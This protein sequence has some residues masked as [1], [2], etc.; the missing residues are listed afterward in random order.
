MRTLVITDLHL[1]SRVLGLLGAQQECVKRI[2]REEKPDDVIIMGDVFMHRKPSPSSLLAFKKILNYITSKGAT[3]TVLRGNHDSETKADDGVTALSVFDYAGVDIVTLARCDHRKKRAYIPHYEDEE[4][5]IEF[6]ED[7]PSH[8][9]AFGHFGYDGCLN[10]VGDADFAL[11]LHHFGCDTLLGH[12]HG[13]RERRG[14]TEENPSRVITLGTPYTTNYGEAFKENFYGLID[15]NGIHFKRIKH[16]PRHLVYSASNLEN[17][18]DIINDPE[19]FTF[20]RVVRETEDDE[21]PLQGIKV[22][23]MDVKYAPVFN[24]DEVSTYKP[25]RDLF[26]I[27]D[28][29]IQDYVK[30][31]ITTI[32]VEKIMEGYRLLQDEN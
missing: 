26:S 21:I 11:G 5:I 27:N 2:V 25:G 19:Y 7:I 32:P 9:T 23:H 30:E 14:G 16:G 24:E 4:T 15:E 8:Y 17:N 20:L 3:V 13:F 28:V 29:V 6:L 1:N 22:A 10:S 12:I 18:L 31:A